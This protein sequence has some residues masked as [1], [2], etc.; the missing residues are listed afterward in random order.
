M[1]KRDHPFFSNTLAMLRRSLIGLCMTGLLAT[2]AFAGKFSFGVWGDMP[3]AKAGDSA[4]MPALLGSLNAARVDFSVFLGDVK[5]GSSPCADEVYTSALAMFNSVRHPVVYTPGDN[6]W[7]DC[8]R[9]NNGG[10]DAL[11]R[12]AHL[13]KVFFGDNRSLGQ[14]RLVLQDQGAATGLYKENKRLLHKGV[15]FATFNIPGSNNNKVLD[16]RDCTFKSARTPAQCEQ[17]NAEYLA[18]DE[19]NIQWARAAFELAK[20]RGARGIVLAFQADPGFDLPETEDLD[21]S[22][23]PRFSGYR[24]FIDQ[25]AQLT[26]GYEGQVLLVHG[27]THAFKMDKPLYGPHRML[28]N[29]TRLQGFGS[30]H[31]HWVKVHVDTRRPNVF[32]IEPVIVRQ[33]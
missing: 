17:A 4:R 22:Q 26:S 23:A 21:E 20:A 13:R 14:V 32:E 2:S 11:E 29:L 9:L 15:V 10:H 6:E 27:D 3:Y 30:P 24:R 19:A 8:H 28:T 31:I 33:P 7:T 25:V 18:R 5:D 1:H 12:L 16:A